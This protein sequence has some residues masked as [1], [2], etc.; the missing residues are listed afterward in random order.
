M[1][2]R[3]RP[4][5]R[6]RN[7]DSCLQ[8]RAASPRQMTGQT[9]RTASL[10]RAGGRS[11]GSDGHGGASGPHASAPVLYPSPSTAA[12]CAAGAV[13][14]AAPMDAKAASTGACK[15]RSARFRTTPTTHHHHL[16]L[17]LRQNSKSTGPTSPTGAE[18]S[19]VPVPVDRFHPEC[20]FS[21]V[22]RPHFPRLRPAL[23]RVRL[24]PLAAI[25]A[26]RLAPRVVRSGIV[27]RGDCFRGCAG[28]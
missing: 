18:H 13:D 8:S 12:G 25:P 21:D 10:W 3:R 26:L 15:P 27:R 19:E 11:R 7:S 9:T 17:L 20:A 5:T 4:S 1:R 6:T 24:S 23:P 14:A 2:K 28:W 16:L 22:H